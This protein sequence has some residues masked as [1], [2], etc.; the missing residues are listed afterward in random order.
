MTRKRTGKTPGVVET[1]RADETQIFR[2]YEELFVKMSEGVAKSL[3]EFQAAH[4]DAVEEARPPSAVDK[5]E[6][7][8]QRMMIEGG[9]WVRQIVV[10]T[11]DRMLAR[12]GADSE[13]GKATRKRRS[14]FVASFDTFVASGN[15]K[16]AFEAMEHAVFVIAL[17]SDDPSFVARLRNDQAAHARQARQGKPAPT[18]PEGLAAVKRSLKRKKPADSLQLAKLIADDVEA[19]LGKRL[20]P[21]TIRRRLKRLA[22]LEMQKRGRSNS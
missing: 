6:R 9:R 2:H 19:T 15:P 10:D 18:E 17:A 11:A 4:P 8:W 5:A 1:K 13:T 12:V 14:R 16:A 3:R 20:A 7:E 21:R 22:E